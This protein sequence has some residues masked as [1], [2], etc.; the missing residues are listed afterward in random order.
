MPQPGNNLEK[1]YEKNT[2]IIRVDMSNIGAKGL[3]E[4]VGG[5]VGE[6]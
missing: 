4:V 2:E 6:D 5:F 3:C 1:R